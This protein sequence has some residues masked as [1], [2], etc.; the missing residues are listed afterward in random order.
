VDAGMVYATDASTYGLNVVDA[1][2]PEMCQQ[3]IYPAAVMKS[4]QADSYDAA[5]DFLTYLYTN[6]EAISVWK[7]VGFT[8]IAQG[9]N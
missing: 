5:E 6:E 2:T 4:G 1:A 7:D 9:E 8:R 3:L